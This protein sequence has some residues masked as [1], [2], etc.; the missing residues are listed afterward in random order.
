MS[1]RTLPT[2]VGDEDFDI[3]ETEAE[4]TD[5]ETS[6]EIHLDQ[7]SYLNSQAVFQIDLSLLLGTQITARAQFDE[8]IRECIM[9]ATFANKHLLVSTYNIQPD[10]VVEF[11]GSDGQR[12]DRRSYPEAKKLVKVKVG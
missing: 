9:T 10:R 4:S 5:S 6:T 8:G 12:F 3:D 11:M 2:F 1:L 7:N